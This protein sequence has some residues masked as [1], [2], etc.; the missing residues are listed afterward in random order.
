MEAQAK[1]ELARDIRRTGDVREFFFIPAVQY[2]GD[3]TWTEAA[4]KAGVEPD[5]LPVFQTLMSANLLEAEDWA[6]EIIRRQ[7]PVID[8]DRAS[9]AELVRYQF[10]AAEAL[11]NR[12]LDEAVRRQ[13]G[14]QLA[15]IQDRRQWLN[16]P[17]GMEAALRKMQWIEAAGQ[18]SRPA[19]AGAR[20]KLEL[21]Q[22]IGK[23][24]AIH[25]A[26][27][28]RSGYG[29]TWQQASERAGI[30][31]ADVE[32]LVSLLAEYDEPS[33]EHFRQLNQWAQD[34]IQQCEPRA[35]QHKRGGR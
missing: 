24:F 10:R 8:I 27:Q 35:I 16:S 34:T 1:L 4:A 7:A 6:E 32:K 26:S 22:A 21:A 13:T 18:L 14:A 15:Q 29:L 33:P 17:D 5:L 2:R 3:L 25:G 9:P 23:T 31:D 11:K 20:A 12:P 28:S 19:A 30:A